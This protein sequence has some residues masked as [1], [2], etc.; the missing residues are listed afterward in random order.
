MKVKVKFGGSF[1]DMAGC[2]EIDLEIA[3][4]ATVG[5]LLEELAHRYGA[6]F[7][8]GATQYQW[9]HGVDWAMITLNQEILN[10]HSLQQVSLKEGDEVSLVPPL[11]G[12]GTSSGS[13]WEV[14]LQ[15]G[16]Q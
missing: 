12:G 14:N 15:R 4:N 2:P 1:R 3:R 16:V 10:S 9:R 5:V 8:Q 11:S 7:A 13:R 6:R